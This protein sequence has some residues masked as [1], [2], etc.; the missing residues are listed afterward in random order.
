MPRIKIYADEDIDV[1]VSKAL[2]LRGIKASSTLESKNLGCTDLQQLQYAASQ[3][4]VLLTHNISDF[5]RIHYDY[6]AS[7]NHHYGIIL[8]KQVSVGTIIKSVLGLGSKLSKEEMMDRLE[9]L[10]NWL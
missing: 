5:A 4:A 10:S 6:I 8:A 7:G 2:R 1:A 3:K 9:Y